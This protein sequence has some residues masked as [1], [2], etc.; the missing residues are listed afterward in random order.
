M[1][2]KSS[3]AVSTLLALAQAAPHSSPNSPVSTADIDGIVLGIKTYGS[4]A[5]WPDDQIK[6]VRDTMGMRDNGYYTTSG[7]E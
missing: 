6:I 2:W 7:A 5:N 4:P 3:I 1:F